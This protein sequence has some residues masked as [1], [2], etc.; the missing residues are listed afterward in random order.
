LQALVEDINAALLE[1]KQHQQQIQR[2]KERELE[3]IQQELQQGAVKQAEAN[4]TASSLLN[5]ARAAES[6]VQS[7]RRQLDTV[8]SS[9]NG[10]MVESDP[11]RGVGN[12][13]N[14][15]TVDGD[16]PR[17]TTAAVKPAQ[18]LAVPVAGGADA[19]EVRKLNRR[20]KE[21]EAQLK[22]A[23]SAAAS[24]GGGAGSSNNA[25]SGGAGGG[26]NNS[27]AK[28]LQ[29]K[30]KDLE[31]S[32]KKENRQLETR[33]T[34][35]EAALQKLQASQQSLIAERDSL[36]QDNNALGHLKNDLDSFKAKAERFFR[37]FG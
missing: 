32:S 11:T 34:K 13:G 26:G 37:I 4:A 15:G 23:A 31:S 8:I 30:L 1:E 27:E 7:L 29:R 21:L 5:R 18:S 16:A 17:S 3:Q 14:E 19:S 35:A 10:T 9:A 28:L 25:V 36:K 2:D 12:S 20:V 33:A 22:A 24:G 6:L